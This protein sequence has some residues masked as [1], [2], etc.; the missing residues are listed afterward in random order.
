MNGNLFVVEGMTCKYLIIVVSIFAFAAPSFAREGGESAIVLVDE[1]RDTSITV[2]A[3]RDKA[4]LE[5]TGLPVS[6][7]GADEIERVQGA[8]LSR[9][10]ERLP[11]VT[12][13]RNGGLG[14]FTGLRV[15]GAEAEQLLVL[16]DGVRVADTASP[17]GGLDFGTLL[18]AAIAKLELLRGANSTIWGSDAMGGVLAVETGANVPWSGSAEFGGPETLYLQGAASDV[19]GPINYGLD[20][21]YLHSQGISSAAAGDEPDGMRQWQLGGHARLALGGG[22]STYAQVR[23]VDARL[24]LD[25]FPA[26]DFALA[27]TQEYQETRR[28]SGLARFRYIGE[29]VQ[30]NGSWSLSDSSRTSFDPDSGLSPSYTAQGRDER[31]ALRGNWRLAQMLQLHFGAER[32]WSRMET[33]F[34]REKRT[35][36][37]GVYAQTGIGLGPLVM[38]AGLRFE[39]HQDFGEAWAAGAD[40]AVHLGDGWRLRASFGEGFKAPSLFQLYSDYGNAALRPERST[41]FDAGIELRDRNASSFL[42][43]SIFRRNSSDLIDFVSCFGASDGI[44]ADRPFGTYDNI[45]MGRA[46]GFETEAAIDASD[47]LRLQAN[48][49][50]VET[51]NRTAGTANR[52]NELARRPRSAAN[53][54][55]DWQ[56]PLAG[57]A[58]GADLRIV[59]SSFDDAANLV[60]L[61]GYAIL[62]LRASLALDQDIE[63]FGRIENL[64]D[65]RYQTAAGYGT[66]GRGAYLG[67]RV[68][69]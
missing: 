21:A 57:L 41:A 18:P 31:V 20:A 47:R 6:I 16:I 45:G 52:G 39:D 5:R 25:G 1:V 61:D 32:A 33:I 22:W 23:H 17:A 27:D 37:T 63:L 19:A 35:S 42:A 55:A 64:W 10:V 53:L 30:F 60:P 49:S 3:S 14:A 43:L 62:T 9:I 24:D 28:T 12:L 56:A 46:E 11:G 34:D 38:N 7:M 68:K 26:P 29:A 54:S 8:D 58:L 50:Y 44:C 36:T 51:V 59:S 48:Y 4:L 69:L 40:A 65:E 67:A 66:P 13:S 2:L 15:R